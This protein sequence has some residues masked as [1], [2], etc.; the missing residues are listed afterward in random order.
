MD[1]TNYVPVGNG[2]E[3]S[4]LKFLQEAEIPVHLLIQRKLGRVRATSPFSS[5]KKRSATAIECPDRPHRVAVYVKGAPEVIINLC[6][7]VASN[8]GSGMFGSDE[9]QRMLEV[10]SGMAASPL[11][12][13]GFA[14]TEMDLEDWQA[15]EGRGGPS[16]ERALEDALNNGALALTFIGV[17]GLKDPLRPKVK[18]AVTY[19]RDS[20]KLSVRLVS[21]DHVETAKAVALKSGILKPEEASKLYSVMSA[22]DFR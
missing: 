1:E 3:V 14:F 5:E 12:V 6:Q 10:V 7:S 16:P 11:R 19:A 17:F 20:G 13:I 18:S 22:E 9:K 4:L 21:G 15:L 2:T 8:R